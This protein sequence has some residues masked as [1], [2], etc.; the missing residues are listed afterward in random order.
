MNR[1]GNWLLHP[2][3]NFKFKSGFWKWVWLLSSVHFLLFQVRNPCCFPSFEP[4]FSHKPVIFIFSRR[5]QNKLSQVL[6]NISSP[7]PHECILFNF[8]QVFAPRSCVW[9]LLQSFSTFH[10]VVLS[11]YLFVCLYFSVDNPK[12]TSRGSRNRSLKIEIKH[13]SVSLQCCWIDKN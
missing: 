7:N 1:S 9:K 10:Q 3:R 6:T 12:T 8:H 5:C 11:L 2:C 4:S 13:N